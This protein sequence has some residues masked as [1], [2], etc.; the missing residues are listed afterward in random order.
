LS[1]MESQRRLRQQVKKE[2]RSAARELRRDAEAVGAVRIREDDERDAICSAKGAQ[3][4]AF[5]EQQRH[6]AKLQSK[7]VAVGREGLAAAGRKRK[8]W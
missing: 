6:E 4:R 1:D 8:K 2:A 5:F 3:A 7:K